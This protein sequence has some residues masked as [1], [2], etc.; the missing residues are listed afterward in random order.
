MLHII[1]RFTYIEK[2][3]SPNYGYIM[4]TNMFSMTTILSLVV[5]LTASATMPVLALGD[6]AQ[7]ITTELD[8]FVVMY[9]C[10]PEASVQMQGDIV[11]ASDGTVTL[12]SQSGSFLN[13]E[14]NFL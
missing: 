10:C 2:K 4:K 12:S 6:T 13:G 3:Y 5:I 8:G 14:K 7:K 11:T 1:T 9:G